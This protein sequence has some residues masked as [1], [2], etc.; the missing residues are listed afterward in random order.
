MS[1]K[2]FLLT[3]EHDTVHPAGLTILIAA[4]V[5]ASLARKVLCSR[6]CPIGGISRALERAGKKTA[7]RRRETEVLLP[8]GLGVVV[9]MA[10]PPFGFRLDLPAPGFCAP[11]G[12]V[13]RRGSPFPPRGPLPAGGGTGPFPTTGH[14]PPLASRPFGRGI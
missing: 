6:V 4:L 8:A 11:H 10:R 9:A 7:W 1:L 13:E 5:S 3:G 2:Y 12:A 14:T